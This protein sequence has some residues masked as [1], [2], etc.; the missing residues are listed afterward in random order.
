M[1]S[2]RPGALRRRADAGLALLLGRRAVAAWTMLLLLVTLA[3]VLFTLLRLPLKDDV[4]WLLYVARRW[5]AGRELYVDVVEVNPPLIVWISAVPIRLA[6]WLGTAPEMMAMPFFIAVVLGCAW[7]TSGL[8]RGRSALFAHRL[9][10]F[11][12]LGTVLLAVPGI[13]I[14]Q[15]EH[16][17]IA[18]ML[19]FL[20]L[21]ARVLDGEAPG[22]PV[23]IAAGVLAG[24][25]CALKPRYALVFAALEALALLRGTGLLRRPWNRGWG[26]RAL[27]LGA[28]ATLLIYGAV[29]LV[30][31]P[32]YVRRAVPMALALYGATDVPLSELLPDMARVLVAQAIAWT[33][34]LWSRGRRLPDNTLILVLLLVAAVCTVVCVMDGKNWFYHRLPATVATVLA[35]LCW[36]ASVLV[37]RARWPRI[38]LPL[39]LAGAGV[40]IFVLGSVQRLEPAVELA[41]VPERNTVERL[42]DLIHREKAHRYIAFSEWIALGF[43]VVNNTG[44]IWTSRFD[45]MWALKGELWRVRFDPLAAKEWPIQQWVA[46]DFIVG[47]PDLA[48]VDRR[49]SVDYVAVL[50][51][52]DPGFARAWSHFQQI[53]AFDGLVIYKRMA[54]SCV[55]APPDATPMIASKTPRPHIK[56]PSHGRPSAG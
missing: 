8:L 47:C 41:I 44:V 4:A 12:V 52:S 1:E 42:E 26:M 23:A 14:G 43:P 18:A 24:L 36:A 13:E 56:P 39:L 33:L 51:R 20:V 5:L 32:N 54:P 31:C 53:D 49:G 25:G 35:L 16:L 28:G 37:H 45:S 29:V 21:Y 55:E 40:G 38:W 46:E 10:V 22:L 17:L 48:V 3:V 50:S 7:W 30:F 11:A 34:M 2:A 27:S 6:Q 19:P 9:P 15:R